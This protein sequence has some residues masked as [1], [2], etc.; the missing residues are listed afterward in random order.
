MAAE[1]GGSKRKKKS[2]E[3]Q[4]KELA[5]SMMTFKK[6]FD[7]LNNHLKEKI[8][9][10]FKRSITGL[11]E[12]IPQL[13]EAVFEITDLLKK[14]ANAL[15]ASLS[16]VGTAG[17]GGSK[18]SGGGGGRGKSRATKGTAQPINSYSIP[19]LEYSNLPKVSGPTVTPNEILKEFFRLLNSRIL[20]YSETTER[21]L[22]RKKQ[23]LG[24]TFPRSPQLQLPYSPVQPS[25]TTSTPS[26]SPSPDPKKKDKDKP[27]R[28]P[29]DALLKLAAAGRVIGKLTDYV[30]RWDTL[31]RRALA[32]NTQ[33]ENLKISTKLGADMVELGDEMVALREQGVRNL[34]DSTLKLIARMK[35]TDQSTVGLRNFL[36]ENSLNLLLNTKQAQELAVTVSKSSQEYG[37]RQDAA[38]EFLNKVSQRFSVATL[39]GAS[40]ELA[41]ALTTLKSSM[42]GRADKEID[43]LAQLITN[44]DLG[45]AMRSG[46]EPLISQLLA[47]QGNVDA[48]VDLLRQIAKTGANTVKE[49]TGNGRLVQEYGLQ[50]IAMTQNVLNTIGPGLQ[51][52]PQL[53][54]ALEDSAES[55]K[56]LIEFTRSLKELKDLFDKPIQLFTKKL[57]ELV[58]VLGESDLVKKILP[59]VGAFAAGFAVLGTI[60][61]AIAVLV[62]FFNPL[63]LGA[64]LVGGL[65][66]VGLYA[67][68]DNLEEINENTKKQPE[69]KFEA[70][71]FESGLL[72]FIKSTTESILQVNKQDD[73][74]IE[75]TSKLLEEQRDV[76]RSLKFGTGLPMKAAGATR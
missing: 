52:L 9:S 2:T 17:A 69:F 41:A 56:Q 26:P 12:K 27:P 14:F 66:G 71:D 16:D 47:S 49:L 13:K 45:P 39:A 19:A 68:L 20:G 15:K 73:R 54:K 35:M 63:V 72:S 74:L 18:V 1:Q 6:K 50:G 3:E 37:A 4:L 67:W 7:S 75:V 51:S 34:D 70:G 5:T 22:V 48:Q 32:S 11:S 30:E 36:G 58:F 59:Y 21:G 62:A 46:L 31:Q 28:D 40:P 38:L 53:S 23:G 60:A 10:E 61:A 55:S 42:Q 65:A 76:N 25:V 24:V 64:A 8:G 44:P 33:V 43:Q 29:L 57:E